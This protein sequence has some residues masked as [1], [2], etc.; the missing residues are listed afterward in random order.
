MQ[1]GNEP[2]GTL[3]VDHHQPNHDARAEKI[4]LT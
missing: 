2:M 4:L 3:L 1:L